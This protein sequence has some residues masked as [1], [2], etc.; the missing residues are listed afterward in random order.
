MQIEK[1]DLD[2]FARVELGR[3]Y[4][5][6]ATPVLVAVD[7]NG[8]VVDRLDGWRQAEPTT[9]WCG[10]LVR[11]RKLPPAEIIDGQQA[12]KIALILAR[13]GRGEARPYILAAPDGPAM[14]E[15]RYL[16]DK[17]PEDARWL[18]DN[19]VPYHDWYLSALHSDP[20]IFE[21]FDPTLIP[22]SATQE[23]RA[24]YFAGVGAANKRGNTPLGTFYYGRAANILGRQWEEAKEKVGSVD[25]DMLAKL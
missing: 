3:R 9:A 4:N 11:P 14:R 23:S 17:K 8:K 13:E 22:L 10:Q 21:S 15:A 19:R 7:A 18:V 24:A 25:V 6:R 12:S 20:V 16:V 1:V 2:D 5:V